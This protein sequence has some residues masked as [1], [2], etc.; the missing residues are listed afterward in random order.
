MQLS[1]LKTIRVV[2][3]LLL[4]AATSYAFLDFTN[5]IPSA[6]IGGFLSLQI[7]PACSA[8]L[9]SAGTLALGLAASL[10]L[11]LLFGRVYCSTCCPLGTLQ[12]MVI[13]VSR[14]A[15]K[16]R[17]HAVLPQYNVVRYGFLL[18]TAMALPAGAMV[19]V[20]LL[21]PFSCFGRVLAG[22]ARPALAGLNNSTVLGLESVGVHI[23]YPLQIRGIGWV[24][25]AAPVLML[26]LVGWLA[27]TR[28]RVYCNTVCPVGTLLGLCSR[29][30]LY[31]IEIREAECTG[32]GLCRRVCKAGCIDTD[33]KTVDMSRCVG[34]FNCFAAC[35]TRGI[36]YAGP[37]Q[38]RREQREADQG[39]RSFLA[40]SLVFLA[41][42]AGTSPAA[43][44]KIV[45]RS[46]PV[47]PPGADRIEEFTARCTAC[48]LCIS[49][50]PTRVLIPAFLDYGVLGMLQPQMD[51]R[52]SF[53]NFDCTRCGDVCPSG[54]LLPMT[55]ERKHL[56]QLGTAKFVKDNCIVY[57]E[58]T[59]CG[60]CSEHC[61]TKA[62]KMVPYK[63]LLAPEV[64]E[65]YCIGCGACEFACPTKPYKAIYVEGLKQRTTAKRIPQEKLTKP[66]GKEFPF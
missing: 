10:L 41:G 2:V 5:S 29:H 23:L 3:S 42:L 49:V 14:K 21:D 13:Y 28:G 27:W 33:G 66:V 31:R 38:S 64:T 37:E 39:K 59:E 53:C 35:P 48:H 62:V 61:P 51:Y 18:L 50:C 6:L 22:L 57:T 7:L 19:V 56:T 43:T 58:G 26:A 24:S 47:A 9:H 8:I 40:G 25:V 44:K 4:F 52:I 46:V 60:A 12:D 15:Q 16:H 32:C 36:V 1:N 63:Q 11:T 30:A 17:W 20:G 54:A 34:C 45:A 55:Q 65:E